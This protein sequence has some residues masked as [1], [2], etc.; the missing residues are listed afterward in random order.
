[1]KY[2][3][4]L[5]DFGYE[6]LDSDPSPD[7]IPHEEFHK[8]K[9]LSNPNKSWYYRVE[10]DDPLQVSKNPFFIETVDPYL[11]NTVRYLMGNEIPTTPSCTGHFDMG[12]DSYLKIYQDLL[13]DSES[14]KKEGIKFE[15]PETGKVSEYKNSD[16]RLPWDEKS[17][18]E[19]IK[20]NSKFGVIGIFDP[21]KKFYNSIQNS[22][23]KNTQVIR[24]EDLTI[25]LTSANSEIEN[26]NIWEEFET[27]IKN[28]PI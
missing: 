27:R 26:K 6:R 9:W 23:I 4:L 2:I 7:F 5:E 25:F 24:D 16:Y 17:F 15:D 8:Y 11:K 22:P 14:I 21:K 1:M 3:L 13:R 18:L 20:E 28:T 12:N 19:R 10:N